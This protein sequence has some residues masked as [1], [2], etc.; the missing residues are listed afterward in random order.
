M[1]SIEFKSIYVW[2][3]LLK[4]SPNLKSH[5]QYWNTVMQY[6]NKLTLTMVLPEWI[7]HVIRY[8]NV[9]KRLIHRSA[10]PTALSRI[11]NYPRGITLYLCTDYNLSV[12][13]DEI[14][15][16]IFHSDNARWFLRP[17][18]HKNRHDPKITARLFW[19]LHHSVCKQLHGAFNWNLYDH[20]IT[21]NTFTNNF[22][23]LPRTRSRPSSDNILE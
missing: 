4:K 12:T 6:S 10:L 2:R 22:V 1:H 17:L 21:H 8:D 11:Q 19:P 9:T 3:F 15:R 14:E 5:I 23:W 13:Q 20:K 18:E 7:P 16:S